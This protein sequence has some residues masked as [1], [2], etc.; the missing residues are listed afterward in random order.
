MEL[1]PFEKLQ[2]AQKSLSEYD[3]KNLTTDRRP[4]QAQLHAWEKGRKPYEKAVRDA[5]ALFKESRKAIKHPND[6]LAE[7]LDDPEA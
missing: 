2:K 5:S 1:T 4:T 6:G 7:F 3:D